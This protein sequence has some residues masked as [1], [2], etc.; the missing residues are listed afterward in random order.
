MNKLREYKIAFRGLSEG[1]HQFEYKLDSDFFEHFEMT[2]GFKGDID[3]HVRLKK[4]SLLMELNIELDGRVIGSCDYCLGDVDVPI[5]GKTELFIVESEREEGNN[6]DFV[7]VDPNDDY[8]D[9]SL[10]LYETYI[11]NYPMKVVHKDGDCDKD[12]NEILDDY[13]IAEEATDPRWDELKKL[14]NNE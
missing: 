12:M 4:T 13:I 6:D 2:K 3:A 7:V 14:I 5:H 1:E 9:T 8:I 10:Y 11:L